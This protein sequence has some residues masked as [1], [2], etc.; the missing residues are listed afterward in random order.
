MRRLIAAITILVSFQAGAANAQWVRFAQYAQAI[1]DESGD[2]YTL[3]SVSSY[4]MTINQPPGETEDCTINAWDATGT[5]ILTDIP[6]YF[7]YDLSGNLTI[8]YSKPEGVTI[9]LNYRFEA[10]DTL[11]STISA[12]IDTLEGTGFGVDNP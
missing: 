6:G 11:G 8:L 12:T 10:T 5:Q 3:D 9:G 2:H 1:Q 7:F 4:G